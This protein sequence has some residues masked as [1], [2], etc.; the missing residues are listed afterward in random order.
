MDG[1]RLGCFGE[2]CIG[3]Q[4]FR[5][6]NWLPHQA[7]ICQPVEEMMKRMIQSKFAKKQSNNNLRKKAIKAFLKRGF[8]SEKAKFSRCC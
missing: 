5:G 4:C 6:C 1:V 3:D 2:G 8:F 7:L